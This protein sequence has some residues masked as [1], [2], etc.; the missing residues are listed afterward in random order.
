MIMTQQTFRS[1]GFIKKSFA[2]KRIPRN[3]FAHVCNVKYVSLDGDIA[4]LEDLVK[5]MTIII[6]TRAYSISGLSSGTH[7]D[8]EK[9]ELSYKN[10]VPVFQVEE[11]YG[12]PVKNSLIAFSENNCTA[13]NSEDK[14][15]SYV[16]FDVVFIEPDPTHSLIQNAWLLKNAMVAETTGAEGYRDLTKV[17]TETETITFSLKGETVGGN[18]AKAVALKELNRTNKIIASSDPSSKPLYK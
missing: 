13:L 14:T 6:E 10:V 11:E 2:T 3:V 18:E 4:Y 17:K 9:K 7:I 15:S 16:S 12:G 1:D 8:F 5:A